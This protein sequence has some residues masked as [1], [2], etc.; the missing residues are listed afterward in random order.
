M[1][2]IRLA[3]LALALLL[4]SAFAP[5]VPAEEAAAPLTVL[6]MDPL[7]AP[8]SCPCVQGYAQRDYEKLAKHLEQKLKRPV[9]IYFDES[10][11][12]GLKKK[13]NG[14]ADLVIGKDSVVR[15]AANEAGMTLKPIAH[16]SGKDG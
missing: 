15:F 12:N 14:K 2:R 11:S 4:P 9:Q 1:P 6:V 8:L 16:L 13:T 10:F 7:A 5:T 3:L